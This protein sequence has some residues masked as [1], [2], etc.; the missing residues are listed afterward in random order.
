MRSHT[1][2]ILQTSTYFRQTHT[3]PSD[4]QNT[5]DNGFQAH[6]HTHTHTHKN[7]QTTQHTHTH[8][9]L[10]PPHSHIFTP[11]DKHTL[12]LPFS[13]GF[14]AVRPR[15]QRRAAAARHAL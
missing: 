3:L 12:S 13:G 11:F 5:V 8:L 7:I 9:Q 6:T 1:H 15:E 4:P 14:T 10:P 2:Y